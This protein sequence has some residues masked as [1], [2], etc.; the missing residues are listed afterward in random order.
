MPGKPLR[1]FTVDRALIRTIGQDLQRRDAHRPL[2]GWPLIA[3]FC[4]PVPELP[5]IHWK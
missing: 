2:D 1:G 5:M 4:S 3:C